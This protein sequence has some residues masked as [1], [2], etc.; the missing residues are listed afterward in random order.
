MPNRTTYTCK[1]PNVRSENRPE[2]T[3]EEVKFA[4]TR[5]KNHRISGED[6]ITTEMLKIGATV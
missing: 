2:I 3:L 4:S 6:D 1:H 5:K